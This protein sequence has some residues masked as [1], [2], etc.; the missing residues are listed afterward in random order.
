[1]RNPTSKDVANLAGCSQTTVSF[2]LNNRLDIPISD[3]TRQRVL[4]AA[5]KLNYV[6]NQFA[7]GLKTNKSNLIGLIVPNIINPFF[8]N[9][10]QKIE[11]YAATK[12]YNVITCNS[13]R[14][15]ERERVQHNLLTEKSVD[16]IIYT[17]TPRHSEN[18]QNL[19]N[20]TKL[21]VFGEIDPNCEL[22]MVCYDGYSEGQQLVEYLLSLGHR[23]ICYIS[24]PF[25]KSS[26]SR[27]RRLN[28]I[29]NKMKD[30][31]SEAGLI[32]KFAPNGIQMS[33]TPLEFEIGYS[34][35]EEV[36]KD[37]KVTAI[38]GMNDMVAFGAMNYI[39]NNTDLYLFRTISHCAVSTI[40]IL[41]ICFILSLQP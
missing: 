15:P 34:L 20:K 3:E 22:D 13:H 33:D 36:L 17:F 29:I 9:I 27:E 16:G 5:K 23:R 19:S 6:P 8:S 25:S 24:P 14:Q 1:M 30:Y 39:L 28:G 12:G 4:D 7:K 38:I 26:L 41:E 10:I 32:V 11:D 37:T 21:L 18:I 35:T 31:G 40:Y 2:V